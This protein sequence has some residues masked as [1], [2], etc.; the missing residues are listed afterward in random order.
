LIN[1][2]PLRDGEAFV[3]LQNSG[4]S[5]APYRVD[6]RSGF[7]ESIRSLHYELVDSWKINRS[8]RVFMHPQYGVENYHGM[9]FR[10][11]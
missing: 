6:D 10:L 5:V 4:H 3:T 1:R 11:K 9:Y 7:I 8:F 2:V